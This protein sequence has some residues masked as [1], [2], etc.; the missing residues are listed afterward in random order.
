MQCKKVIDAV[1]IAALE[2]FGMGAMNG[3]CLMSKDTRPARKAWDRPEVKRLGKIKDVAGA[4]GGTA[5][6][7]KPT[8]RT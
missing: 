3:V 5:T 6:N 8:V 4:P 7:N 2:Q 1:P